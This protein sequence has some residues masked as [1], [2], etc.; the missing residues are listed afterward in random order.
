M[1][2]QKAIETLLNLHPKKLTTEDVRRVDRAFGSPSRSY[3][4]IHIAG[5]NGKGS[6]ATKMATV[7]QRSGYRTALYTSPHLSS[8]RERI[9]V[10]GQMIDASEV[11][12]LIEEALKLC[13]R[14]KIVPTFFE[15]ATCVALKY[16][17]IAKVDIAVVEVGLGGR[18][19]ATNIVDPIL[20]VITSIDLDH[21]HLLGTTRAEIAIEKA[22]IIKPNRPV[23]VGPYA[24][25]P[26]IEAIARWQNAPYYPVK[27]AFREYDEENRAI[28]KRALDLLEGF[29]L[30]AVE[31]GLKARPPCRMEWIEDK[32][33]ILDVAHNPNGIERLLQS[34]D[35]Y[36]AGA[37]IDILC[38]FSKEKEVSRALQLLAK[39]G[40]LH[41]V[42]ANHTRA[43]SID[44]LQ[45][46]AEG[47][48]AKSY[49]SVAEAVRS[50][51]KRDSFLLICGSF[52][53]MREA[54]EALGL[55]Q[56]CDLYDSNE[57]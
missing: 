54:K 41:L 9:R 37:K 55:E 40:D 6:T 18:L 45:Q 19:D 8:F 16:F 51:Q 31:E 46:Q 50:L 27:G 3:P 11:S 5:T 44:R 38:G 10:D 57:R 36:L 13:D 17:Q 14:D 56:V 29:S 24:S 4:I 25:L 35:Q 22:G 48:F 47:L 2:Y 28:A 23:V 32:R 52:F 26:E 49:S 33:V 42:E 1:P 7:L 34:I 43:M 12:D 53:L 30:C 39:R 15:V 20:S 21:T